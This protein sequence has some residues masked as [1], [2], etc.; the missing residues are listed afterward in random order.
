MKTTQSLDQ[1]IDALFG[2][3]RPLD[4][5][6]LEAMGRKNREIM[7]RPS[8]K[9]GL[10]KDQFID[11]IL[12]A[13]EESGTSQSEL[14]KR[15]G[16]SRQYLS[17]LLKEDQRVNYTIDTMVEVMH[18]LGRRV[19]M[20][21]PRADEHTLVLHCLRET[22]VRPASDSVEPR[23]APRPN[24]FEF[25]ASVKSTRSLPEHELSAA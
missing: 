14:A 22:P 9:A 16:K 12:E 8:F 2:N 13:M 23:I 6:E 3:A 17:K 4:R 11:K 21:F 25:S 7:D 18:Q 10:I 5:E 1:E 19:E 20:H 15:C 24:N